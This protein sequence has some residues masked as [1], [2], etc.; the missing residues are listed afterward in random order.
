MIVLEAIS[1]S[2]IIMVNKNI[3]SGSISTEGGNI[4]IGDNITY[5]INDLSILLNDYQK[6]LKN[7]EQLLNEFK[8]KTA[9]SL[10]EDIEKRIND[11]QLKN[12]N[13]TSK[14][15]FLKASCKSELREYSTTANEFVQA[16]LLNK[17]DQKLKEKA[18]VEYLNLGDEEK[19]LE[20]TEEILAV[21]G[22][23]LNAWY[24]K[25]LISK[26][27]EKSFFEVPKIV[28]ENYDFQLNIMHWIVKNSKSKF[29]E[30]MEKLG[31]EVNIDF[32]KYNKTNF[33]E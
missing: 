23:N 29:I 31:L 16:Y 20:L 28:S 21:D 13:I 27:L 30:D 3:N 2:E 6:Q 32:E 22:N 10:L 12:D 8:P 7:I 15:L 17:T 5:V 25:L 26:D 9:L 4:H 14:I 1:I 33:S 11:S 18:C 19:S 24:V